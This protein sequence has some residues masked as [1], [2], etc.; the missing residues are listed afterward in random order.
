MATP[1]VTVARLQQTQR[2][3]RE[4]C[5]ELPMILIVEY[6][7]PLYHR[8]KYVFVAGHPSVVVAMHDRGV[9]CLSTSITQHKQQ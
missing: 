3:L 2:Y 6:L 8:V 5:R 7:G 9:E 4:L 1:D